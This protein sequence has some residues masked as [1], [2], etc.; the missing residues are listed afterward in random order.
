[1]HRLNLLF[2]AILLFENV[3]S[4]TTL[5]KD[6][7]II[8]GSGNKQYIGDI[9]MRGSEIALI[10]NLIPLPNEKVINGNKRLVLAPGFIDTHSHHDRNIQDSTE[11]KS[12]LCQGITTLI[13]GQDGSSHLPLQKFYTD[14]DV[15]KIPVNAAS[16]IGHNSIRYQVLGNKNFNREATA[17]EISAMK[18][19][20]KQEIKS[21]ALGF[22]TGLEYD[23]GIFSS[24]EEVLSLA[25][26]AANKDLMY[27][28]HIRSEDIKLEEALNE[29][30]NIGKATKLPVQISHFK[31]AMKAKWGASTRL[32][33]KLDSARNKGIHITADA[34]PYDYWLS[35]LEVQF[36]KRD[37]D[38]KVSA[39]YALN[40]LAPA[41]GMILSSY[42]ANPEYV[43]KSI[44]DIS[45]I[46][47][48]D[49]AETYMYLIKLAR[50]TKSDESVMGRSM[51]ESD[52]QN[53]LKW[54]YTNICSDGFGGGRHPRGTGSFPRVL[55]K[56]VMENKVMSIES[57]I[58]K[59][60]WLSA[61]NMG[62]KNRGRLSIGFKA[63]M[64]II[65]PE[66][67]SDHS[68]LQNPFALSTGIEG[69]WVNG[70]QVWSENKWNGNLP[71]IVLK[72]Y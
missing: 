21:G 36:P 3:F 7:I 47:N 2:I 14:L 54:P 17:K 70:I 10:G 29:I 37:F 63:D 46:I 58:H 34:Y 9:R 53:I 42:D 67:I 32:L 13:F 57:A 49:P 23:P 38:N 64:V 39:E 44:E 55:R 30:I 25:K 59:M 62:I 68:T 28:S 43:G 48:K 40:E 26:T 56:Y 50:D 31:V 20:L 72:K 45:K 19:L 66:T 33:Q 60:T 22:S 69:V 4:Q 61:Q 41:D 51:T 11:Y 12:F 6:F 65:D 16:F 18:K 52:I 1:M 35:T 24:K 8:D 5:F 27:A 15:Q 71:G